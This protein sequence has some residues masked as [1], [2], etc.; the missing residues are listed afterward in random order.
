MDQSGDDGRKC[1]RFSASHSKQD[2]VRENY[3]F[4]KKNSCNL[5]RYL[6]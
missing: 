5:V 2:L 6:L 4:Y 3:I 1:I